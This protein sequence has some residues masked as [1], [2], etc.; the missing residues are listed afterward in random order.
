MPGC[1]VISKNTSQ[2]TRDGQRWI[3]SYRTR[4][5]VPYFGSSR[6]A[7]LKSKVTFGGR[8]VPEVQKTRSALDSIVF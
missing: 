1:D 3:P 7:R 2:T 8:R 4:V 5:V 6:S